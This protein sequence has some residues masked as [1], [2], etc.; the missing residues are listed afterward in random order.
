MLA[1]QAV[2]CPFGQIDH[3]D[4]ADTPREG[5]V[6]PANLAAIASGKHKPTPHQDTPGFLLLSETSVAPREPETSGEAHIEE[7]ATRPKD[8]GSGSE[9]VDGYDA[10]I[11]ARQD[12]AVI[13]AALGTITD[14]LRGLRED[15]ARQVAL[16][17][18]QRLVVEQLLAAVEQLR[19]L[20][21]E[22]L[23]NG[24]N[25]G[26]GLGYAASQQATVIDT[27]IADA[28]KRWP[29]SP[30]DKIKD[31]VK[32]VLVR[33]WGMISKLLTVKEWTLTGKVGTG[34]LGLAEAS[35]SV[36]FGR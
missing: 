29:S 32:K 34:I 7:V 2:A 22:L 24:T 8:A 3:H 15:M 6:T 9:R 21:D 26:P 31:E 25:Q 28:S 17:E 27:E 13:L 36:A 30:W 20:V 35:V 19:R 33:L 12:H 23:R 14:L 10:L 5:P 18:Q 1:Y 16:Q 11:A 4:M